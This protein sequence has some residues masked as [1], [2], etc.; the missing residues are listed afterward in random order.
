MASLPGDK[1]VGTDLRLDAGPRSLYFRLRDARAEA[2]DLERR[3]ETEPELG[4]ALAD[5]WRTV[6]DLSC[7]AL[8]THTKDTEIGAW[9]TEALTRRDGLEGF[10]VG[11]RILTGLVADFWARGLFPQAESDDPEAPIAAI[12]GLNGLDRD[13]TL[14]QPL[15]N[16]VL[17]EQP[18]G[19]AVTLWIYERSCEFVAVSGQGSRDIEIP[20][21][22]PPFADLES[23]AR[24]SGRPQLASCRQAVDGALAA[25][26]ELADAIEAVGAPPVSISRVGGLLEAIR[27]IAVRYVP[28]EIVRPTD[29]GA[30]GTEGPS[31]DASPPAT[32]PGSQLRSREAMLDRVLEIASVF[33]EIEPS[34]P[35]GLTLEEAVR[36]ARLPVT[37]LLREVV[38]DDATRASILSALGIRL[39]LE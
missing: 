3:W 1:P 18:D 26:S 11:V 24:G 19:T 27:R 23:C 17:F 31:G 33:R 22:P 38:P 37:D 15:R 2:R 35:F 20:E 25:W 8:L 10:A 29:T 34:S 13:G 39:P 9:L 5:P 21:S 36:R 16:T 30:Q 4:G 14:M 32:Y 7:E 28:E 12:I 6:V